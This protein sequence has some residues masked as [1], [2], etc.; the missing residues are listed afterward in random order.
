MGIMKLFAFQPEG[1]GQISLFVMAETPDAAREA[2]IRHIGN[3]MRD[4]DYRG[5]GTDHYEMRELAVGEVVEN[6][7]D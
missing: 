5:W 2:C 7:N 1:H 3:R 4:Y 6:P